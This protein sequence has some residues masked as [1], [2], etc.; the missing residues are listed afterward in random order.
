MIMLKILGTTMPNLI[1][2]VTRWPGIVHPCSK[3][4]CHSKIKP[5]V[6]VAISCSGLYHLRSIH[7][8]CGNFLLRFISPMFS[9]LILWHSPAQVCITYILF[10]YTV[11]IS[12][13]GLYHLRSVH[14]YC[15]NL[16]LRFVSPTFNSLILWQSPARVYITYIQFTYTVAISCSGLYHLHSI[17]L[18][19]DNLLLRLIPPTFCSL[20]N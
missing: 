1:A 20:R 15:G 8:Y 9:S 6:H 14:L 18:Y 3:L 17:H 7:L 12:C 10:T 5:S 11:A 19:C 16:L 4:S 13:S 2:Q